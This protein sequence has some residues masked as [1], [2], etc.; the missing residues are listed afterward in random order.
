MQRLGLFLLP[1]HRR[2]HALQLGLL[3]LEL[4]VL[5]LHLVAGRLEF[6]GHGVEPHGQLAELG[7][8]ALGAR[9]QVFRAQQA[10]RIGQPVHRPDHHLVQADRPSHEQEHRGG[11]ADA[12]SERQRLVVARPGAAHAAHRLLL[13]VQRDELIRITT[14]GCLAAF[15]AETR[16]A[17]ARSERLSLMIGAV[18]RRT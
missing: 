10:H 5:L 9:R 18:Q 17:A 8:A 16:R 3:A 14:T 11:K 2:Q 4:G 12:E 15:D 1:L 6:L 13:A 7:R